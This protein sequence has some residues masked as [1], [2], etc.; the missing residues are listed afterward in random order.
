MILSYLICLNKSK[1]S[2]YNFDESLININI[3]LRK[4]KTIFI[5]IYLTIIINLIFIILYNITNYLILYKTSYNQKI[6]LII[7]IIYGLLE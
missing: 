3:I 7:L 2:T 1:L 6:E 5:L 4:I